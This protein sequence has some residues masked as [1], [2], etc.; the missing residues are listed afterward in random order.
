MLTTMRG[1]RGFLGCFFRSLN[2]Q[3]FNEVRISIPPCPNKNEG[4]FDA[5]S[6]D[7]IVKKNVEVICKSFFE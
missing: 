5:C 4:G 1:T 6:F 2:D 7:L 3:L